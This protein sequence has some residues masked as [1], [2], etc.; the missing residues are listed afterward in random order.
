MNGTLNFYY[1][2]HDD[3][4]NSAVSFQYE[5]KEYLATSSGQREF[6]IFSNEFENVS[7]SSSEEE[8]SFFKKEKKTPATNNILKI[9]SI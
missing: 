8:Y 6:Q 4:L 5:N 1:Q 7:E 3:C 2:A 9:W